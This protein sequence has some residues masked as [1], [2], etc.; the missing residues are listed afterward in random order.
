MINDYVFCGDEVR[1]LRSVCLCGVIEFP[2]EPCL[3]HSQMPADICNRHPGGLSRFFG[4][5]SSKETHLDEPRLSGI[6]PSQLLKSVVDREE[7]GGTIIRTISR[8]YI[9]GVMK[10]KDQGES[11][12]EP[13]VSVCA[14]VP[15]RRTH[16]RMA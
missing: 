15:L 12:I 6:L 1:V 9:G 7:H 10:R 8:Q 2:L 3:G 16:L 14:T 5:E 4:G 11:M 13:Q